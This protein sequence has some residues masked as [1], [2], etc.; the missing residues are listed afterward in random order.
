LLIDRGTAA[1]GAD[2]QPAVHNDIDGN[3]RPQG[4]TWDIGAF[5]LSAGPVPPVANFTGNPTSG[6]APL[7]VMFTD[8]SIGGPTSWAWTF[9]DGGTSTAQHPSHQYPAA[10]SYT[11]SLTASNAQVSNTKTKTNYISVVQ[12]QDYTCASATVNTGT[13]KSGDHTSVHAS[14]NVYLVVGS[15]KVSN[16]Q[17]AQVSYSFTTGLASL[18]VL[19]VTVEGKVS[20]G[21]QPVTIYAYNYVT[22]AWVAIGTGTF[23]T[24][25]GTLAPTV[26][27]PASYLSGG[28]VQVRVKVGGSGSTAFDDS[29]DLVKITA[30]P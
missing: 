8:T 14:D 18:S 15:A 6:T 3:V 4:A 27:S 30:A 5:E 9:G 29:T 17:T 21:S 12:A 19:V 23:T 1:A 11:V 2:P 22:A 26:S 25:D 24:T 16:K 28:T 13:L 10:G 7:T 20:A